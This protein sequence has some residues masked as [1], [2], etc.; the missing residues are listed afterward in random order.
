MLFGAT[1]VGQLNSGPIAFGMYLSDYTSLADHHLIGPG[2]PIF[3]YL[4]R[5]TSWAIPWPSSFTLI[6]TQDT[7]EWEENQQTG[8]SVQKK[9]ED[10]ESKAYWIGAVTGP[11]EFALHDGLM[12]VPRMK[13]LKTAKEHPE[14][15]HAEWSSTA[16]Y[17]IAWVDSDKN[18]SGF[19]A[20]HSQSIFA[21]TGI[22]KSKWKS[23]NDWEN[24]KYYVNLDGVVLG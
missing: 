7:E 1:K 6:A 8:A 23:V 18:V 2:L 13:L 19:L 4:S 5:E 15:L 9:W 22:G 10:R 16:G 3:A 12:P 14:Q 20:P 21:L 24:F 17:G 11:W